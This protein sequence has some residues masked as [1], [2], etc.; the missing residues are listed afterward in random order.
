M[1]LKRQLREFEMTRCHHLNVLLFGHLFTIN[2]SRYMY[3]YGLILGFKSPPENNFLLVL[4]V[5]FKH[6]YV[7]QIV[8]YSWKICIFFLWMYWCL[9]CFIMSL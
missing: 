7:S 5:L 8:R 9:L 3:I 1:Q 4:Q 6:I 2:I